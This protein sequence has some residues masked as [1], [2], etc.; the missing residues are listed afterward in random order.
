MPLTAWFWAAYLI[1]T[2][3]RGI[4]ALLLQRQL[5]LRPYETAWMALHKFH[6][7]MVNLEREALR[8]KAE[9][10]ETWIGR[11]QAGLRGSG[12]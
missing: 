9:V 12:N 8:G 11:T 6:R 3:K 2:N 10:D 7:A 1:T 5:G 4:W